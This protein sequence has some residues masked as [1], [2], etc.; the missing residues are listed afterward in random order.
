MEIARRHGVKV[1][2]DASHSHGS[3]YQGRQTGT[4][5]DIAGLSMMSSKAFAIGEAGMMTTNSRELFERCVA[6][7]HYSA[8]ASAAGPSR[9]SVR[10]RSNC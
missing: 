6:Y 4:L 9:G 8:P 2:E 3:L 10:N 7:G 1:I 5:G